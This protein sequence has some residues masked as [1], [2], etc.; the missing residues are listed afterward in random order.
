[1]WVKLEDEL[2][3]AM[4]EAMPKPWPSAAV[5]AWLVYCAR[6]CD[7]AGHKLESKP[8]AYW[9]PPSAD[10]K[11][12]AQAQRCRF[13]GRAALASVAGV[14]VGTAQRWLKEYRKAWRVNINHS[15]THS[16]NH[17][18]NRSAKTA[19]TEVER[20]SGFENRSVN[21][22]VNRSV[23]HSG[24][25]RAGEREPAF[26]A[27]NGRSCSAIE[28]E[29]EL[30]TTRGGRPNLATTTTRNGKRD[31][32]T[33][34]QIA[35]R[36]W[37]EVHQTYRRSGF[38]EPESYSESPRMDSKIKAAVAE[39]GGWAVARELVAEHNSQ[40]PPQSWLKACG[41]RNR[42]T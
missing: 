31:S 35:D 12:R 25:S 29:G 1:M 4:L 42:R 32:R 7:P 23:T 5:F 3:I 22:S 40:T 20:G 30:T 34:R 14:G 18:V 28:R 19:K 11:A 39:G 26:N 38:A 36:A 6:C 10:K 2:L 33:P 8:V 17:S 16:V 13:P 37:W 15:V 21:H 41:C 27:A 24:T 9:V